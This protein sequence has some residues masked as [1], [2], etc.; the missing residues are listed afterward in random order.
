MV[1][2]H[3]VL[4]RVPVC[5]VNA[6]T[7]ISNGLP[8]GS[9][10]PRETVTSSIVC[11]S[12]T[13]KK[14]LLAAI[15]AVSLSGALVA[16]AH[17][18]YSGRNFG[19]LVIDGPVV[20]NVSQTI[21]SAFGWADGTDADWG[22]SHRGR[23]YRFTLTNSASVVITAQR[24][25]SGT[26]TPGTFLPGIS[27]FAGWGQ[28]ASGEGGFVEVVTNDIT[29][30]VFRAEQAAHDS[31]ALSVS[32]R[33]LGTEGSFRPMT[34]WSIGNDDTYVTN[35]NPSSGILIAAR[36]ATFTYI[37]HAAD[38]V[39]TNY[40]AA[41]GVQGDG[42]ADGSVTATFD[43]LPAGD[44]SIFIGGANYSKQVDEPGPTF[45][46]YGVNVGVRARSLPA[47]GAGMQD[48]VGQ[49]VSDPESFNLY[50]PAAIMDMNLGG[51]VIHATNDSVTVRI[52]MQSANDL[53]SPF[54]DYGAPIDV[55][56]P[57]DGDKTFM[58]LNAT[59]AP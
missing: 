37:G 3:P 51:L 56:I 44:Y 49:V 12:Y 14:S 36:L 34:S 11:E 6:V 2:C 5:S 31:A 29:N 28:S 33:P 24:N 40:G 55:P 54:T 30:L 15:A 46:T 13:M 59:P 1:R 26:G 27:L 9:G 10:V 21:S 57:L 25:A 42:L 39:A 48:G 47:Y 52:Q 41:L 7:H 22:D 16:S 58:R 38:G 53:E 23:F 35:G 8:D 17:I 45:P 18:S 43:N 20:S 50:T 19:S 4:V 32:S